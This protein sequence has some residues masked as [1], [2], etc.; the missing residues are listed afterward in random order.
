M[1]VTDA[2]QDSFL[3]GAMYGESA[4][5]IWNMGSCPNASLIALVKR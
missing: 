2:A 4:V 1:R 3:E 5:N